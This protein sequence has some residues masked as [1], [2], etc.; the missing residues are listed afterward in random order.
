MFDWSLAQDKWSDE[1]Q[2]TWANIEKMWRNFD[3]INWKIIQNSQ[4][5]KSF[6]N[7]AISNTFNKFANDAIRIKAWRLINLFMA[8]FPDFDV[9]SHNFSNGAQIVFGR[10]EQNQ[11]TWRL[12]NLCFLITKKTDRQTSDKL[13][14]I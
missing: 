14:V 13:N 2:T 10:K 7:Q 3:F 4:E 11:A 9:Y 8:M 1:Q 5:W 6:A 12:I